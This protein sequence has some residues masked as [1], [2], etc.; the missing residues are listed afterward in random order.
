MKAFR[1]ILITLLLLF[2]SVMLFCGVFFAVTYV[3]ANAIPLDENL[4][5]RNF[6]NVEFLDENGDRIEFDRNIYSYTPYEEL[7]YN[8]INAFVSIEDKRFFR[9]KGIDLKRVIKAS[10]KNLVTFSFKEGAS[11]ISQQLVKNTLLT[12]EK[13]LLRKI[14][15]INLAMRLEK[16]Y[17]K[18]EILA[19]YLSAIYFGDGTYGIKNA[20]YHYF[21]KTPNEL[22]VE[23]AATLAGMI[24]APN[25]YSPIGNPEKTTTRR[26]VVLKTMTDNGYID[27]NEYLEL[28][29]KPI[30]L[31]VQSRQ[32]NNAYLSIVEEEAE[33]ILKNLGLEDLSDYK[34]YTYFK[35]TLYDFVSEAKDK[36][37][38][39]HIVLENGGKIVYVDQSHVG[40]IS[41]R[42]NVAS[43][44]K[45]VLVYAPALEENV[46]TPATVVSDKRKDYGGYSPSNYKNLYYGNISIRTAI[47]KSVNTVAVEVFNS[48][49][50]KKARNYAEKLG[51]TLGEN[52]GLAIALGA[53]EK[54]ITPLEIATSYSVFQNSGR[55]SSFSTIEKITDSR[56]RTI[57][58]Y[59]QSGRKVFSE[60][61]AYIIT[62]MLEETAK[63]GTAKALSKLPI[64]LY[65]KTGTN[66]NDKQNFDS[67]SIAFDKNYIALSYLSSTSETTLS[68]NVGG[69]T[70]PTRDLASIFS[71]IET[72]DSPIQKP[73]GVEKYKI[74][75]Y[76]AANDGKILLA[77]ENTPK[78]YVI[79][80]YFDSSKAPTEYSEV[81]SNPTVGEIFL[82]ERNE[83]ITLSFVGKDIY[84]YIV[85]NS[86]TGDMLKDL[87]GNGKV[88]SIDFDRNSFNGDI[89]FEITPYVK[90]GKIGKS[91]YTDTIYKKDA[92][93]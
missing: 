81:F 69:G 92:L 79:E 53:S 44:I 66:G 57:Y 41:K 18:K 82:E 37:A 72:D 58:E 5:K 36:Y 64:T 56:G 59:E 21:G 6:T 15:E 20:A 89:K 9:H 84:R 42:T 29:T 47:S 30:T 23:E 14:K 75:G 7:G 55:L 74:D 60:E 90:G 71:I 46:I 77:S 88:I 2:A 86:F 85:K 17:S 19:M 39:C 78:K 93:I 50:T 65:A 16:A 76:V 22:S 51:I 80:E 3:S 45:P 73:E 54:G 13:T 43:L 24:K 38:N 83:L 11:T 32:S 40:L 87:E 4:L 10:L 61:T 70:I 49:G 35:P 26:N 12:N 34:V 33:K 52:D 91:V 27:E 1:K 63:N 68:A 48:L 8:T 67:F 28:K 62:S 25:T 31:N